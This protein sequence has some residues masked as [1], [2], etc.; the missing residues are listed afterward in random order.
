MSSS[1]LRRRVLLSGVAAVALLCSLAC[2]PGPRRVEPTNL[3]WPLPPDPPRIKY[4]ESI[5]NEDDIGR[6][7]SLKEKLFGKDYVDNLVRPYGVSAR[8]AKVLVSDLGL[9]AVVVFNLTTKR[10]SVLGSEGGLVLPAAAVEAADGSIYVADAG[11]G[12][13]VKY[14]KQGQYETA[15]RLEGIRPVGIAIN[16]DSGR[17]YVVD[18][19]SHAVVVCSL[20]GN[21]LFSFGGRGS[22][23]G[24]F[25]VPLGIALDRQGRVYVLDSG[26]FRVQI[27][28]SEGV[29]L[30]KFGEVGDRPGL[31]ANPKGIALDSDEHVYVTDAAFSNFQIF[32][33]QGNLRL[34]VG[35]LGS[36]PGKFH[37]PGGI[38]I[39]ENDR[40]YVADQLNG[41]LEVFQYL[42]AAK[43]EQKR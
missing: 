34:Y 10:I 32:D 23:D 26:N 12:R 30:S 40:I 39:D 21:K 15:F 38:S 1:F 20:D 3:F 25:N 29:F 19:A 22:T 27:F 9:H 7:Y 2:G 42:K 37:L 5:Y 35:E 11:G 4:I 17:L 14:D 13:I 31:L 41:R 6:V 16:E 36:T 28:T 8:K 18:R 43:P 24:K 33:A